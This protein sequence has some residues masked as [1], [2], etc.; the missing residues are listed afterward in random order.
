MEMHAH[1]CFKKDI[2]KMNM[3]VHLFSGILKHL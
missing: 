2:M 3:E 1:S